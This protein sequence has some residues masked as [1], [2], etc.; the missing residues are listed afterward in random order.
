[1][2][3]VTYLSVIFQGVITLSVIFLNAIM[4]SVITLNVMAPKRTFLDSPD[5]R[6]NIHFCHN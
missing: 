4:L 5:L 3:I 6:S 1:V 2:K